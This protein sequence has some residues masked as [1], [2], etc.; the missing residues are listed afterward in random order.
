LGSLSFGSLALS[1]IIIN[2]SF[3]VEVEKHL[4]PFAEQEGKSVEITQSLREL[5]EAFCQWRFANARVSC[6]SLSEWF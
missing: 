1:T 5:T 6:A 2:N 4:V 3:I